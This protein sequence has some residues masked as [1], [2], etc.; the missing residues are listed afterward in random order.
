MLGASAKP[1]AAWR[2]AGR[3]ARYGRRRMFLSRL[4]AATADEHRRVERASPLLRPDLSLGE[5]AGYLR[6]WPEAAAG[7][8]TLFRV[9]LGR[10]GK[11]S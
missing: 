4:R 1:L 2:A 5:Y 10:E 8:G 6:V 11:P 3:A 7:G 9:V